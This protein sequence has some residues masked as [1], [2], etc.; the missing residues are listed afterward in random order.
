MQSLLFQGVTFPTSGEKSVGDSACGVVIELR[1]AAQA[2][3]VL[4]DGQRL[5]A[6]GRGFCCIE[7]CLIQGAEA[8]PCNKSD[9]LFEMVKLLFRR[10]DRV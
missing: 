9:K 7:V 6:T 1:Q 5:K 10:G 2:W 8:R 4:H 3:H